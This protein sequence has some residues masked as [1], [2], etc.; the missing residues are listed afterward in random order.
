MP[1]HFQPPYRLTTR[2]GYAAVVDANDR[3][4]YASSDPTRAQRRLAEL[5]RKTA[6][7]RAHGTAH[8]P[9]SPHTR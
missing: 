2:N 9:R 6:G 1:R 7:R 8:R 4:I 3:L 5:R